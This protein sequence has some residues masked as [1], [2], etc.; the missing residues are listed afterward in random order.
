MPAPDDAAAPPDSTPTSSELDGRAVD[1]SDTS[2]GSRGI[3]AIA[4]ARTSTAL[5]EH[6]KPRQMAATTRPLFNIVI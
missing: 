4:C 5:L 1:G 2:D 3:A 6:N